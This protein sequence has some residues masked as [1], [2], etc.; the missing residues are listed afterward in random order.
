MNGEPRG[1]EDWHLACA[2]HL[3]TLR[4]RPPAQMV[5]DLL[6]DL[7]AVRNQTEASTPEDVIELQRVTAALASVHADA[8]TRLGEHD[9][10]LCW[11]RTA[12]QAADASGDL[13]LR[14]LVRGEEARSRPVRPARPAD[15]ARPRR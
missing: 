14:L 4:T 2:D 6:I 5:A 3:H 9:A 7:M 15:H 1:I 8:L 11:W 10:A 13:R 12:R